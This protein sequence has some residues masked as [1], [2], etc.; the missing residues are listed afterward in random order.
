[1]TD[2]VLGSC[3]CI[4]VGNFGQLPP[5]MDLTMN[6]VVIDIGKREFTPGLTFVACSRVC[7]LSDLV[8]HPS[9]DYQRLQSLANSQRLQERK[10]EDDRLQVLFDTL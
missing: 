2:E 3:S 1:M 10:H 6:K 5:V 4:L 9:F 8:F 7:Q